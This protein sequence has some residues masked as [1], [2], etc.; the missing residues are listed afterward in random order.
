MM[1]YIV[2][3]IVV[4]AAVIMFRPMNKYN[5]PKDIEKILNNSYDPSKEYDS[6]DEKPKRHTVVY[7]YA[8]HKDIFPTNLE[9]QGVPVPAGTLKKTKDLGKYGSFTSFG[10]PFPYQNKPL[11][12]QDFVTS[13][14]IY[15]GNVDS[16]FPL[17]EVRTSWEKIGILTKENEILNLFRRPIAPMQELWEYQVQDKDGFVIKLNEK[18]YIENG[19]V[20]PNI[21]GKSGPW[22]AHVFTENK[23]VLV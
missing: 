14:Q 11:I 15:V 4:F 12:S 7:Q 10:S 3:L 2:L 22:K 17:Q 13:P 9:Y 18:K 6:V 1:L 20:I 5:P 21:I 16:K 23:Y 19:D 8:R